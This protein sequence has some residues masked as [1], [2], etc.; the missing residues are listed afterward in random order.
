[1]RGKR[2]KNLLI[3]YFLNYFPDF[4]EILYMRKF[5][6]ASWGKFSPQIRGKLPKISNPAHKY[7]SSDQNLM[8]FCMEILSC[9]ISFKVKEILWK[10]QG[11]RQQYIHS[12]FPYL[13][14]FNQNIEPTYEE[15][16]QMATW[17]GFWWHLIC[18]V[19]WYCDNTFW[20]WELFQVKSIF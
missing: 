12:E 10:C 3:L 18:E 16:F 4:N 8:K 7:Q 5:L 19:L 11:G 9:E 14:E 1:M 20:G 15:N 13:G 17:V 6:H 2:L